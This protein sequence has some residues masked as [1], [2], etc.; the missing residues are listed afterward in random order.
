MDTPTEATS[1]ADVHQKLFRQIAMALPVGMAMM[2]R[3]QI[4][5]DNHG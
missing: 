2:D 1:P 4:N 5:R 3:V